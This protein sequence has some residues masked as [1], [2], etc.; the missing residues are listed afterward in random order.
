MGRHLYSYH[1]QAEP[2]HVLVVTAQGENLGEL[3][4]Q[5]AGCSRKPSRLVY[6]SDNLLGKV[7]K[8]R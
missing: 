5:V 8:F 3:L 4:A 2:L 7:L 1:P 6:K